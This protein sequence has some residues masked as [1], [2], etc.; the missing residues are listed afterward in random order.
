MSS[1]LDD[2][3]LA[4]GLPKTGSSGSLFKSVATRWEQAYPENATALR[5]C[6]GNAESPTQYNP[7]MAVRLNGMLTN[8]QSLRLGTGP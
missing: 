3:K 7:S 5:P 6:P 4:R 2:S 8:P 1:R